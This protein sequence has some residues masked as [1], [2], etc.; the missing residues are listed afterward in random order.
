MPWESVPLMNKRLMIAVTTE[1][2]SALATPEE[3]KEAGKAT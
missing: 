1:I 3:T 2:L